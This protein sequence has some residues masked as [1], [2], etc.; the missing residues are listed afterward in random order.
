MASLKYYKD[1]P[2]LLFWVFKHAW[3]HTPR[4]ILSTCKKRLFIC[5]QK[6]NFIPHVFLEILQSYAN[7]LFWVLLVCLAGHTKNE[8]GENFDVYLYAKKNFIIHL[9]L[10]ILHFKESCT[11]IGQQHFGL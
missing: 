8:L 6:I 11:L 4:K 7:I 2:N 9:F 1:I 5:R 3:L 10:E